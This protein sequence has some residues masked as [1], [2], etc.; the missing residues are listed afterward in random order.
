[1]S[2]TIPD[3]ASAR[4]GDPSDDTA[5]DLSFLT[6]GLVAAALLDAAAEDPD[7]ELDDEEEDEDPDEELDDEDFVLDD[8]D[9]PDE[10]P[11]EELDEDAAVEL[12][13]ALS[14]FALAGTTVAEGVADADADEDEEEEE[15]VPS[16]STAK[17]ILF[18][19]KSKT[20]YTFF[21]KTSPNNHVS[22]PKA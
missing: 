17:P 9:E 18:S 20:V 6:F 15:D 1:M 7:E 13:L 3:P 19:S 14:D 10:V 5:P 12:A 22:A 4:N 16:E 8:E 21:R 11:L 2:K